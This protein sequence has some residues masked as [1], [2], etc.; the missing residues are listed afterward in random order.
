MTDEHYD[1]TI[2]SA[3]QLVSNK[4]GQWQKSLRAKETKLGITIFKTA[5]QKRVKFS[6][7][8]TIKAPS[9]AQQFARN[10]AILVNSKKCTT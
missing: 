7:P 9:L 4:M 8:Q 6:W 5:S 2:V 10:S 1:V 3:F